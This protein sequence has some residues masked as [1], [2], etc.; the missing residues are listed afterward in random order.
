[1]DFAYCGASLLDNVD[2]DHSADLTG[3]QE[4]R[5][6]WATSLLVKEVSEVK[7]RKEYYLQRNEKIVMAVEKA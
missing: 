1:M 5:R 2:C 6:D 7:L 4:A 3:Y